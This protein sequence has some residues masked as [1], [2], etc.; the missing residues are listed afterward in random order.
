MSDLR[1]REE[2]VSGQAFPASPKSLSDWSGLGHVP[3]P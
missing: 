1:Y 2:Q 3:I